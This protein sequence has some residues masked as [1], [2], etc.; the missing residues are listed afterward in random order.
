MGERLDTLLQ[1]ILQ[2]LAGLDPADPDAAARLS[3]RFP[4]GGPVMNELA[5]LFAKGVAEG[6]LCDRQGGPGISYSRIR[7]AGGEDDLSIDAV[8]MDRPGPGHT[9]P[10]GEFDLCFA[11]SGQPRFDGREPGWTVYAPGTWHVPTV[12]G[13][14]MNI[15]YF[16][17]GGAIEFGPRPE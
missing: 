15:L 11:A 14:V 4:L 1:P 3:E 8:R 9:H 10:N 16:L 5:V 6:W 7:K 17:P 12:T 13:G 2:V